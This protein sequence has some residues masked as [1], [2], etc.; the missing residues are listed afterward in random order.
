[1][2]T[3]YTEV[4]VPRLSE[5]KGAYIWVKSS[6]LFDSSGNMVG[7][8]ESIRDITDRKQVEQQ[9]KF[10]SLYDPLTGLYN[11]AYF[12]EEMRR[13]ESGRHN[14]V[15]IVVCDI[16]GLK[17][18]NDTLG[19]RSG[20]DLLVAAAGVIK[21]PFR[22]GDM[23]ARIG[24][25]EF[26]V[27]LPNC[28]R[29][30]VEDACS[31]IKNAITR[32]NQVNSDLPLSI[33]IGFAASG[34]STVRP[35]DLFIEA[36]NNMYREKLHRSQSVRSA[37]VQTLLK[38]L[39]ERDFITE[40]HADRMQDQ[41]VILAKSI[42]LPERSAADLRLLAQFH[43]IGKVGISD[44]ILLKPGPLSTEEVSEMQRHCEVGHRIAHAA[45]DMSHIAD[46]ILK[47]HEWWDGNGYP[48]GLKGE[49][50]PLECRIL[51][52]IDAYDAMTSDRPYRKAMSLDKAM[53]ELVRCAGTQFDPK[54]V[55]AFVQVLEKQKKH[56]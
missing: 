45:P 1:G 44:R 6:P 50:I 8:I 27:L 51:A 52:I 46:W 35:G 36:D 18:V 42:G 34:E 2:N 55:Q 23:V 5:G 38:A 29:K 39:E 11:R 54:L 12:E 13:L 41:A 48:M 47:H 26:A 24:G 40:G 56:L 33:S 22:E 9:L 17:L 31:R 7:A 53:A 32:Y 3:L 16:D 19:H 28:N 20:D 37:I 15:S 43:D 49:E 4:F 21:E 14:P 30:T 25:D 10:L